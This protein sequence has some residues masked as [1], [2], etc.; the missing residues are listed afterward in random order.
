M[1]SEMSEAQV[2]TE[3]MRRCFKLAEDHPC[4]GGRTT[5]DGEDFTLHVITDDPLAR[6][7][8]EIVRG[9]YV[10]DLVMITSYGH[11][12]WLIDEVR[13]RALPL[14]RR[15]MVLDDLAGT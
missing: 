2:K 6:L 3:F 8:V 4:D 1:L 9:R 15:I 14:L 13:N 7:R 10:T 12:I 5:L 11:A